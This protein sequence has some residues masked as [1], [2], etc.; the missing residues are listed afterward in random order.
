MTRVYHRP[1]SAGMLL[2]VE[3]RLASWERA[4][5]PD[6]LRLATFLD[7]VESVAAS[8]SATEEGR[9]AVELAVGLPRSTPLTTGGR[10]LDNYLYP[11][12]QRLGPNRLAAVFGRKTHGPSRLAVTSARPVSDQAPPMFT[13]RLTG[14]YVRPE[15]KHDLRERLLQARVGPAAPGPVAIDI[16]LTTGRGRN[17]A[18]LWK[19]LLDALG[20][21]LGEHPDRPFH[22]QDDR[23]VSLGLHHDMATDIGHDVMIEAWWSVVTTSNLR[24]TRRRP[25]ITGRRWCVRLA[26]RCY[27]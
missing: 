12:A 18:S 19:P 4:R 13:T 7:H 3:P 6:Q 8:T 10:H 21:I 15:W 14:S 26:A 20:P 25:A 22:P 16:A 24:T 27:P 17:W 11:V 23:I 2:T 1:A 9:L 5:H